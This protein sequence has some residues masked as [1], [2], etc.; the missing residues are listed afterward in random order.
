VSLTASGVPNG[1]TGYPSNHRQ[2]H[3]TSTLTLAASSA[4][5]DGTATVTIT[6]TSGSITKTTI[7]V[8]LYRNWRPLLPSGWTDLDIRPVGPAGSASFSKRKPSPVIG[9]GQFVWSIPARRIQTL[10]ISPTRRRHY[11]RPRPSAPLRRPTGQSVGLMIRE[12]PY[13][14]SAN[15]YMP[16]VGAAIP[17]IYLTDRNATTA[18]ALP[19]RPAT[20]PNDHFAT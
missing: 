11:R 18:G 4:G 12:A 14:R 17:Q 9:S 2:H 5:H 1:V 15:A 16:C 6:G 7:P 19:V 10:H 13:P 20:N 3:R 8:T